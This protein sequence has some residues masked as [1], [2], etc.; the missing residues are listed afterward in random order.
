MIVKDSKGVNDIL[1]K[2][3]YENKG[4]I[5]CLSHFINVKIVNLE[6]HYIKTLLKKIVIFL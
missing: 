4:L 6:I 5:T 2:V 3:I 1:Y